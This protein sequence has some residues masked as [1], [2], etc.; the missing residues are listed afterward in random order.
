VTLEV[1]LSIMETSRI[2]RLMMGNFNEILLIQRREAD[3]DR[4]DSYRR[5]IMCC[6]DA[7]SMIYVLRGR[8][9]HLAKETDT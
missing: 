7:S 5:S 6:P 2:P 9:A 4:K 1:L 3:L 8:S